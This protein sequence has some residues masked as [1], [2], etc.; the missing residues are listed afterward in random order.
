MRSNVKEPLSRVLLEDSLEVSVRD[1]SDTLWASPWTYENRQVFNI[2]Q[3]KNKYEVK[4][5]FTR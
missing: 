2:F 4:N 5:C 3:F 1:L